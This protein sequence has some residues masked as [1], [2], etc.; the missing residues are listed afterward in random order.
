MSEWGDAFRRERYQKQADEAYDQARQCLTNGQL[1]EGTRQL[2]KA[3]DARQKLAEVESRPPVAKK[4]REIMKEWRLLAKKI[5]NGESTIPPHPQRQGSVGLADEGGKTS[6]S[7]R[8]PDDVD[9][10]IQPERPGIDFSD[11]GGMD[12]LKTELRE[13]IADPVTSDDEFASTFNV[14]SVS[15]VLLQGPPG[16]GKT[17]ITRALAGELDSSWSFIDIKISEMTSALVGQGA[18]KITAAF[19]AAREHEPCILFF[20][21]IDTL[22]GNRADST[23]RTQSEKQMLSTMLTEMNDLDADD[24]S[25]VVIGA[26]NAPESVDPALRNP[27]RFSEVIEVPLPDKQA[28]VDILT[29]ELSEVPVNQDSIDF[30]AFGSQ[31]EGFSASDISTVGEQART[32]A[33]RASRDADQMIPVNQQHIETAIGDRRESMDDGAKGGY[34][35]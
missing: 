8:S 26:T 17:H 31:T 32:E 12:G 2:Q 23:Q 14:H 22:A 10:H 21:E 5:Q 29:V 18:K 6:P 27:Q 25:V 33:W 4:H 1:D 13:K 28:R 11:V 35:Q 9:I 7:P 30:D 24:R 20:D 19:D 3:A 16:T 15:G 34:L